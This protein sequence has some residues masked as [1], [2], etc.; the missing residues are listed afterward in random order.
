MTIETLNTII[1]DNATAAGRGDE[2]AQMNIEW[3]VQQLIELQRAIAEAPQ[4]EIFPRTL[5]SLGQLGVRK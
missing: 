3:A 4:V 5:D 2:L 1:E